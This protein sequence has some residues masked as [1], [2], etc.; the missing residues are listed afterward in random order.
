MQLQV[1][2]KNGVH[3]FLYNV[4]CQL[5]SKFMCCLFVHRSNCTF[6]PLPPKREGF[7]GLGLSSC[8][9]S[10]HMYN[11]VVFWL[12]CWK[13]FAIWMMP[14]A[15]VSESSYRSKTYQTY[16]QI[17]FPRLVPGK[18]KMVQADT[19][20]NSVGLM[21]YT[22]CTPLLPR[23]LKKAF[24]P[25]GEV[26]GCQIKS[27]RKGRS[28]GKNKGLGGGCVEKFV[29]SCVEKNRLTD[30]LRQVG[31]SSPLRRDK[32]KLQRPWTRRGKG[33]MRHTVPQ[34]MAGV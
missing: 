27:E 1:I 8:R 25:C 32:R 17:M 18:A 29:S 11:L 7:M 21:V 30:V 13:W 28:K 24:A 15:T 14:S 4:S 2:M 26:I 23:M 22:S 9:P 10:C 3:G 12:K 6:I 16:S 33:N 19:T 5:A 20:S 34:F 31:W